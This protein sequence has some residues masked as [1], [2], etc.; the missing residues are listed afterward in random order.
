MA[1]QLTG[2]RVPLTLETKSLQYKPHALTLKNC[3]LPS[4]LCYRLNKGVLRKKKNKRGV[5]SDKEV[6]IFPSHPSWEQN[7]AS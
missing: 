3:I 4:F 6:K 1:R 2:T 5:G 7:P